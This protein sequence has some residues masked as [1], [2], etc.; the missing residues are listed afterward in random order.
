M[1]WWR[2]RTK[3]QRWNKFARYSLVVSITAPDVDVDLYTE[4]L[5]QIIAPVEIATTV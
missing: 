5:Q 2:T 3:L 4:I 1:G